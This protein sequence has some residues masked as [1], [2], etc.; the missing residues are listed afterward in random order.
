M[1]WLAG[2]L[3]LI[4]CLG[5]F[6]MASLT[7]S[8]RAK[9]VGVR[10]VLGAS[11]AKV[12]V[13]LASQSTRLVLLAVIISTPLAYQLSELVLQYEADRIDLGLIIHAAGGLIALAL[14]WLVTGYHAIRTALANPVDLLRDE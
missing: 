11:T 1:R 8:R 6:G 9:E 12:A 13:L 3:A 4:A 10:K 14:A 2:F 5:L 7:I